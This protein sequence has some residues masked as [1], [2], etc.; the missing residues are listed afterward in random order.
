MRQISWT[1]NV[2]I[3]GVTNS[4]EEKFKVYRRKVIMNLSENTEFI[5]DESFEKEFIKRL[6][7]RTE[8]NVKECFIPYPY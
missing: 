4:I 2:V 8:E 6:R 3:L 1:H 7:L 5:E